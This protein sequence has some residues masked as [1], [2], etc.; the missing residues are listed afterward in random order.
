M[1][2]KS[3]VSRGLVIDTWQGTIVSLQRSG[4]RGAQWLTASRADGACG[5]RLCGLVVV[6]DIAEEA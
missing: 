4:V 5:V 2:F 6:D 3:V 1:E